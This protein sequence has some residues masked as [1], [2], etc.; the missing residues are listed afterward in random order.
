MEVHRGLSKG[1]A[2]HL[3]G[4]VP[5]PAVHGSAATVRESK[6]GV[7]HHHFNSAPMSELGGWAFLLLVR[8]A[9]PPFSNHGLMLRFP[10][11]CVESS[12]ASSHSS[13]GAV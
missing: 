10:T 11:V 2:P 8:S 7:R 13:L 9:N 1:T 5:V 3:P 4:P 6:P 12:V